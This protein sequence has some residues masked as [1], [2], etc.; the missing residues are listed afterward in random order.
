MSTCN[1]IHTTRVSPVFP[2][3]FVKS[4]SFRS[5]N[6]VY[7]NIGD[8][9]YWQSRRAFLNSYH[10]TRRKMSVKD[11][12]KKLYEKISKMGMSVSPEQVLKRKIS[13]KVYKLT[14]VWSKLF[15]AKC[16]VPCPYKY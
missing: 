11:L 5:I 6:G 14:L 12:L 7:Y 15:I 1:S 9:E 4:E 8:Y 13:V 2:C 10:F 16:Y 3:E